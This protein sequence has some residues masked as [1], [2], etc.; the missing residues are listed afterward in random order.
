MSSRVTRS[1]GLRSACL[2]SAES[3]GRSERSDAGMLTIGV[4]TL[5]ARLA[6][7]VLDLK[8]AYTRAQVMESRSADSLPTTKCCELVLLVF[9]MSCCLA[10]IRKVR[11]LERDMA[12]CTCLLAV[13]ERDHVLV[14]GEGT[15]L[16]LPLSGCCLHPRLQPKLLLKHEPCFKDPPL[17]S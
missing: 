4:Q 15:S 16:A 14:K 10:L 8:Y 11:M 17:S 6:S 9:A 5:L 1:E 12:S 2:S 7:S 3:S 13:K